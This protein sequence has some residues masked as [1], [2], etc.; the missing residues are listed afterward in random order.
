MNSLSRSPYA[1]QQRNSSKAEKRARFTAESVGEFVS[2]IFLFKEYYI[3]NR[4][5]YIKKAVVKI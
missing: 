1:S 5:L 4:C 2:F 3:K